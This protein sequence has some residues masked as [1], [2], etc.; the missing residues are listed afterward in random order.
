MSGWIYD[1]EL[2]DYVSFEEYQKK[3]SER[4]KA[5]MV[6]ELAEALVKV[7]LEKI[8]LTINMET[9]EVNVKKKEKST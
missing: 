3:L 5:K 8:T 9:G 4:E 7:L 6:E 2:E 1:P